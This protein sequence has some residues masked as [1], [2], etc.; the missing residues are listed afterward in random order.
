MCFEFYPLRFE[1]VARDSI[2]FP[3]GKAA[4]VLRG[5]LGTI[6]RRIACAPDCRDSKNCSVRTLCPWA[7]LFEP[8]AKAGGP[9]GLADWPR[10]FVFRARHLDGIT[11][12][13]GGS[14]FFD[15]NVFSPDRRMLEGFVLTFSAVAGEGLGPRRGRA[16][17]RGVW[18]LAMGDL[19]KQSLYDPLTQAVTASVTPA[20]IELCP[21]AVA[22]NRIQVNFL[23]P[24]EL[25]HEHQIVRRPEFP[26]LFSRI[27]DRIS[28]LRKLYRGG[29]LA[30]DFQG[31]SARASTVKMTRCDVRHLDSERRSARTG[32]IHSI[33]GLV[34]T[35]EY[36]GDLAEF[37]PF[38]EAAKWIGVGRQSVFGKG[39]I[40]WSLSG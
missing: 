24:T 2:Y 7:M 21:P 10:P 37:L 15:L 5:A 39:E 11:V 35:A 36:E 20:V 4:N 28:T 22:A 33:G 38:L 26:I 30:I 27:R 8:S 9:S 23:S 12:E 3:P 6:F 16:D 14:F 18:R 32:Q 25:K 31:S 17:L 19:A 40:S 29:S 34:G 13:P 1:F